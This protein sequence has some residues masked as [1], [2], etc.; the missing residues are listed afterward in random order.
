MQRRRRI[1]LGPEST[2][3]RTMRRVYV[4]S[5]GSETSTNFRNTRTFD[6][7]QLLS[8]V[9]KASVPILQSMHPWN[10]LKQFEKLGWEEQG[11]HGKY[12]KN[13][14]TVYK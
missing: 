10:K 8:I 1:L 12:A 13:K 7:I 4:A 2:L 6:A 3:W 11:L 5:G 14:P 9:C